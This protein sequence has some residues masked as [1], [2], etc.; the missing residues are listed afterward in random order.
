MPRRSRSRSRS[1][2]RSRARSRSVSASERIKNID[3]NLRS[4]LE[5]VQLNPGNADAKQQYND[6]MEY[7]GKSV[8]AQRKNGR[9]KT[10]KMI[11]KNRNAQQ[12]LALMRRKRRAF[13][14]D[15]RSF[16]GE[17]PMS[18]SPTRRRHVRF[19]SY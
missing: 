7:M 4:H 18:G 8:L 2:S 6:Y 1:G 17:S 10:H 9:N 19:M 5:Y 12:T 14:N 3:H 11:E 16:I 13:M 15:P